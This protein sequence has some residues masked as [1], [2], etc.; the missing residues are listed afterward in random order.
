MENWSVA[1]L[2]AGMQFNIFK[3]LQLDKLELRND[4]FCSGLFN[5]GDNFLFS[6]SYAS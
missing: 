1:F 2:N 5:T 3:I 4:Q 6:E